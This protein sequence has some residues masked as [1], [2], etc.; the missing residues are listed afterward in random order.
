MSG[1]TVKNLEHA[2]EPRTFLDGSKRTMVVLKT[3]AIGRGEY[4]PGW[5]WSEHAGPQTGKGSE[6][7]IGYILSGYMVV[8]APDGEEVTVGPGDGFEVAPGHD[9]WVMGD[10]PC[11]AFDFTRFV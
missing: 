2:D 11:I 7:H 4:L 10:E 6:A 8:K 5:R 9:A 3:A 1:I